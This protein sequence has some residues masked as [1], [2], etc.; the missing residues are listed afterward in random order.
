MT[1]TQFRRTVYAVMAYKALT[2]E[3]LLGLMKKIQGEKTD[4]Q[5]AADL[6]IS[7]QYLCDIYNGRKVPS[8]T[9]SATFG[10]TAK[11]ETRYIPSA[12]AASEEMS[13]APAAPKPKAT[14][15]R[16]RDSR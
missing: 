16:K 3:E 13:R 8:D 11:V 5:F 12:T 14:R 2:V 6:G 4:T 9:V 10:F 7:K 15:A 1:S